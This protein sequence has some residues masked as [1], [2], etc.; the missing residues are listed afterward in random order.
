MFNVSTLSPGPSSYDFA[1]ILDPSTPPF[2][3]GLCM[4]QMLAGGLV[5]MTCSCLV[6]NS[7][8]TDSP[9]PQP[10]HFNGCPRPV[11]VC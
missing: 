11:H 4:D 7:R 3:V 10:A 6:V 2:L 5:F 9:S 8:S 1:S